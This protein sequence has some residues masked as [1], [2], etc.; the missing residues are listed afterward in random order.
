MPVSDQR[1]EHLLFAAFVTSKGFATPEQVAEAVVA[2]AE[3]SPRTLGEQMVADGVITPKQRIIVERMVDKALSTDERSTMAERAPLNK[4]RTGQTDEEGIGMVSDEQP[5]HYTVRGV[6]GRGGQARVMLAFD[7]HIGRDVALKEL[8]PDADEEETMASGRGDPLSIPGIVRFLREA[9]VT[10]QLEH[11]NI[12][13]V[14]ELGRRE[15]G[16]LYYTMRLVRGETLEK[17]LNQCKDLSDRLKHMGPFWD[18]CNAIAYAHSRGVV[19]RDIKPSN[20]MVGEFG[21]T[22]LLDWGIAK[23]KGRK[24]LG[25]REI[26]RDLALLHEEGIEQTVAGSAI[27][28]PSYMSPEQADGDIDHI[29]EISDVWSLGAVLYEILTGVPPYDGKTRMEILVKVGRKPV[30]PV[31]E[32]RPDAPA[33]LTAIAEKCLQKNKRHR[34][35]SARELSEDVGAYMTG[36]RVGAYAYSAWELLKRFAAQNRTT[37]VAIGLILLVI[38][39]ALVFT[40]VAYRKATAARE[41][42]SIARQQEADARQ[43]EHAERL[44]ANYH[45]A[46]AYAEKADRLKGDMRFLSSTIFAAA[47]L[48]HN[49]SHPR[50]PY[51]DPEFAAGLPQGHNLRVEAASQIYRT[52]FHMGVELEGFF[53]GGDVLSQPAFSPTG[54]QLA[55]AS[56]D[57]SIK[58]WDIKTNRLLQSLEAH[59]G[60]VYDV[61]YSTDGK[62]LATAGHD[63]TVIVWLVE[64]GNPLYKLEGHQEPV[65]AVA[66]SPDGSRLVSAGVDGTLRLWEVASARC[67]KILKGHKGKV[68]DAAFSPDGKQI[69]SVGE[70][71]TL[72]LWKL[73]KGKMIH[74]TIGHSKAAFAV[75]FSPDGRWVA[76]A[77]DDFV[78]RLW[79]VG[80]KRPSVH[81]KGHKDGVV[82]LAFSPD[83]KLLASAGYDHTVRIWDVASGKCRLAIDGHKGF[84]NGVAF[85]GAGG[86]LASAGYDRTAKVWKIRPGRPLRIFKGHKGTIYGV[87]ISPDGK[88]LAS[89]GWDKTVRIF[90]TRTGNTRHVLKGHDDVVDGVSISPDGRLLA[91]ASRDKTVRLWSPRTGQPILTLEGHEDVV[92]LAAFSPDGELIATASNDHTVRVWDPET[93]KQLLVLT[94]HKGEIGSLTFSPSKRWLASAGYDKTVRIWDPRNGELIKVL[95]GHTDWI[96]GVDFTSDSGK[97]VTS[98]K[99][100]LAIL[101]DT[102]TWQELGRFSGHK[103]WVNT[104]KLSPDDRLLA[105]ASDDRTVR[106][107]S[108]AERKTLL[109]IP[110][111]REAVAIDFSPDGEHLAVGDGEEVKLYP[112]EFSALDT[113]PQQLLS[114]AE[115]HAG[116][117]LVGFQLT[118]GGD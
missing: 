44:T 39:G 56:Y 30:K 111:S 35:Q 27:G 48:L 57:G 41:N 29:D 93:G 9:R 112:V 52:R 90:S 42:E 53:R 10:G 22:V 33:D 115:Q 6:H 73:P 59:D 106:I 82:S 68:Y 55:V 20:I 26:E 99:D 8:L 65:R 21:E 62:H 47:S 96:S 23:V 54:E 43:Q 67:L 78:V 74:K 4:A 104:V 70:D 60:R 81:L 49:P 80:A 50:S 97:L 5:G 118:A 103:Q 66:F 18:I 63:K 24:D 72:R 3:G 19:H 100:G 83:G 95:G 110:A 94:G 38:I 46:Q 98:G 14:Y 71:K 17:K 107:W 7:E 16:L 61:E 117:K 89:S 114:E 11:P 36:R 76:S 77:G 108:L 86:H 92:Y 12:V 84:V 64:S 15:D 113:D 69:V 85:S 45:L 37:F 32:R 58:V 34:Y 31:R 109:K 116:M 79:K 75:A 105:T 102:S 88:W 13:P 2:R 28:T 101:W 40:T 1:V 25:A 87:A 51:H 91:S